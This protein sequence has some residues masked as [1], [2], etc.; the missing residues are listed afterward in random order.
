M[1]NSD[2]QVIRRGEREDISSA[3][4]CD[5]A[6][7]VGNKAPEPQLTCQEKEE[8]RLQ[9]RTQ[10]FYLFML[11]EIQRVFVNL[12]LKKTNKLSISLLVCQLSSLSDKD[13]KCLPL[14]FLVLLLNEIYHN[15]VIVV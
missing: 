4:P 13:G 1:T 3:S 6:A 14:T 15:M 8:A 9:V 5:A 2:G 7:R 10:L 11:T 12:D